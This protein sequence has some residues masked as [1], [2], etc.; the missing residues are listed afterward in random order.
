MIYF[1]TECKV[2]L[3]N[4]KIIFFHIKIICDLLIH[5]KLVFCKSE[6][7]YSHSNDR[8]SKM[9]F[10]FM[11]EECVELGLPDGPLDLSEQVDPF[12]SKLGG[13]PVSNLLL[14]VFIY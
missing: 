3:E 13:K 10:P 4:S 11:E 9:T 14:T 1:D 5:F 12:V 7:H 6:I 2:I 8:G